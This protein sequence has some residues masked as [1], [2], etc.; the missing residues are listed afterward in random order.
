MHSV[1]QRD[2]ME[3]ILFIS[4][5]SLF[6]G[7]TLSLSPKENRFIRNSN[8]VIKHNNNNNWQIESSSN[9]IKR[10][11]SNNNNYNDDNDKKPKK[12]KT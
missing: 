1:K 11:H 2:S 8:V 3:S 4:T 6:L 5:F 10:I 7:L 12:M 9:E